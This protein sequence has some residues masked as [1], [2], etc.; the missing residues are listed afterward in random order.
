MALGPWFYGPSQVT[1]GEQVPPDGGSPTA[2]GVGSSTGPGLFYADRVPESGNPGLGS[3]PYPVPRPDYFPYS[4]VAASRRPEPV[5]PLYTTTADGPELRLIAQQLTDADNYSSWSR[6]F[7]RALVTKE[8]DGFIDGIVQIPSN[9][10]QAQ[11]WR[12]CNQLV[13]IWI[14]N[15]VTSEVAAE[16]PPTEDP[17]QMWENIKEMYGKLDRV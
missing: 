5:D 3:N 10:R 7:R 14:G 8:K 6:E 15:C 12:K 4:I 11:L 2:P 9:E 17:K 16:L 13:R 1:H